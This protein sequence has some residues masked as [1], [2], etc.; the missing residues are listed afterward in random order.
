[1]GR[2]KTNPEKAPTTP[3][4]RVDYWFVN[5]ELETEMVDIAAMVQKPRGAAAAIIVIH[6]GPSECVNP[7][8]EFYLHARCAADNML[9]GDQE[10][11]L[12]AAITAVKNRCKSGLG[13]IGETIDYNIQAKDYSKLGPRWSEGIFLGRRDESDEVIVGAA[14]GVEHCRA[15]KLRNPEDRHSKEVYN[16]FIGLPWDPRGLEVKDQNDVIRRRRYIEGAGGGVWAHRR[17][18]SMQRELGDAQR[19]AQGE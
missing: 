8:V 15:M 17:L 19:E 16:T 14:R 2:Q 1:E 13:K 4:I 7:A 9:K 5:A 3:V 12:Q 10:P 18:C 11:S 6:K